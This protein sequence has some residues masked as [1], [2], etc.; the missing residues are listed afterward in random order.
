L[1]I[2]ETECDLIEVP[3]QG[4]EGCPGVESTRRLA[5]QDGS[6]THRS[7]TAPKPSHVLLQVRRK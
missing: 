7:A 5:S 1:D 3:H 4:R 2:V 6:E